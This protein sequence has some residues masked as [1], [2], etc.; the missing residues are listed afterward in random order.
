MIEV[1]KRNGFTLVE[2][3]VSLFILTII[4]GTLFSVIHFAIN[5][6]IKTRSI[7]DNTAKAQYIAEILIQQLPQYSADITGLNEDTGA[8]Y[9]ESE[10][11]LK[12]E[13][14]DMLYTFTEDK[15]TDYGYSGYKIKVAVFGDNDTGAVFEAF[16]S[17]MDIS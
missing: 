11:H 5:S 13:N 3:M 9:V 8:V 14:G 16:A 17:G 4:T 2:V 12:R 6:I 15:N 10:Q 1:K 7:N